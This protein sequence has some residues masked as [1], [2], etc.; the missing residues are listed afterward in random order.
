MTIKKMNLIY[1]AT[2]S[3]TNAVSIESDCSTRSGNLAVPLLS[4]LKAPD[5]SELSLK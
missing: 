4:V 2:T 3:S 5:M 1:V